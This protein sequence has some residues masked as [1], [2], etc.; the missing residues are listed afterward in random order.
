M[1]GSHRAA[2]TENGGKAASRGGSSR[3]FSFTAALASALLAACSAAPPL[4][5]T[6]S[7]SP[8]PVARTD[9]APFHAAAVRLPVPHDLLG[10]SDSELVSLLG[11][12]DFRRTEPPAEL[13]QYRSAHCV[14]DLF[15]YPDKGTVRVVH[16]EAHERDLA[17][18]GELCGEDV[19]RSRT[20]ES[21]L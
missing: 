1:V 3:R 21:R 7:L 10:L 6:P 11:A 2:R 19:L 17:T 8:A 5:I 14:L 18:S 15:L 13:W 4:A 9:E 16:S 20:R 12:P